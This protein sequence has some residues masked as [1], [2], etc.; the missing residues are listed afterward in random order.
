MRNRGIVWFRNDLRLKDNET[1]QQAI[2]NEDEIIPLFIFNPALQKKGNLGFDR[3][4]PIRHGFLIECLK[5]LQ[6]DIRSLSGDLLILE[7]EPQTLIPKLCKQYGVRN[8]YA[9]EEVTDEEKREEQSLELS[10]HRDQIKLTL[11]WQSTMYHQEDLQM[12]LSHLSD[13]FTEFRKAH[14]KFTAVR[15]PLNGPIIFVVPGDINWTETSLFFERAD[16]LASDNKSSL[17]HGGEEYAWNRLFHYIWDTALLADYKKTRNHLLGTD[18]SSK[19]SL[20]L[21]HGCI[22]ARSIYHEVKRFEQTVK[23]NESTYWLIF[24]LMWRDYFRFVAKKYGK[25]IFRLNGIK[26]ENKVGAHNISI[27]EKWRVGQTGMPFIDA[28]MRELL[29]TGYMSNRGRQNVASYLVNDLEIDW[30]WG[31]RWFECQLIDYDVC[32][33]WGNWM[34]VA[35]VGNDPREHRYFNILNQ[36]KRY[37]PKGDFVRRWVSELK[38]IPSSQIHSPSL[39]ELDT[40]A[41]TELYLEPLVDPQTWL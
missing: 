19:F 26:E 36:A 25:R 35:G 9:T 20:W 41:L 32:S 14:E 23:K 2:N 12:P 40:N 11:V 3:M 28:N 27:F 33:N 22:T 13:I 1:L 38:E 8:V 18:F 34:Y 39:Y 5:S 4:G 30:R 21:A 16:A 29:S 17:F 31:A 15:L 10:L 6:K 37:D 24:E 7:G